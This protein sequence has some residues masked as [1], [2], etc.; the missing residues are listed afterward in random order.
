MTA[1]L[2]PEPETDL[3]RVKVEEHCWEPDSTSHQDGAHRRE[4]C[5]QH[6]RGLCYQD[7]PGPR[8]ALTQLG[9]LCRRWLRPECHT[10]EQ[11]LDRLVLEQFLSI[12]PR[13]LQAWVRAQH[14]E[15]GEEAVAVLESRERELDVPT[16]QV[17]ASSEKRE[18]LLDKLT[19][20]RR[21]PESLSVQLHPSKIQQEQEY[22]KPLRDGAKTRTKNEEPFQKED[23]PKDLESLGELNGRLSEDLPPHPE[24]REAAESD[25]R[26]K[27]PPR[28][29]RRYTCEDCG[30][31]F[32]HSSDLSKHRRTHTG[33]K[34][35]KCHECGKSFIQRCHLIGHQ[36]VHSGVKPYKCKDC[37]REFSGRTGL[38]Q[39]QRIHT[40]EKPYECH[41]CG[42]PFRVSSGLI[43]HQRIHT[44]EKPYECDECGR[45]FRVSSAL[46][47]HQRIHTANQFY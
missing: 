1:P 22:G 14:P 34:P 10:K 33:E 7:A 44:G 28:G 9:E 20:S 15:T 39:H 19:V 18:T 11:I 29:K 46:I 35:Y 40:G 27:W 26:G 42:R 17:S 36:R 43:R 5:R 24:S 32:G 38:V 41:E 8:E 6:F 31:S 47:R 25:G 16:K 4:L 13:D 21:L 3:G 2:K 45:P 12:L 30:K 37:G 23:R